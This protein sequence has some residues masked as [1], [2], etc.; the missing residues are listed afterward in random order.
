MSVR[1]IRWAHCAVPAL[2]LLIAG[3]VVGPSFTRPP[4]PAA[5]Y[6]PASLAPTSATT[7]LAGGEAQQFDAGG[8]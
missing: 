2:A 6:P 8:N 1:L 7:G 3:C 4:A 5:S